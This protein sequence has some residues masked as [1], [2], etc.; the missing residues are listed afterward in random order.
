[1]QLTKQT[2]FAFRILIYLAHCPTEERQQIQQISDYF[3]ISQNHI[4]KIVVKLGKLGI[5]QTSRGQGGGICL[6]RP[7]QDI[8]LTDIV[9]SMESVLSP[10]NCKEPPC[11]ISPHCRLRG[12]LDNAMDAFLASLEPYTLNDLLSRQLQTETR[13]I[14]VR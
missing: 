11:A 8:K 6:A 5:L 1:M 2:D 7:P 9:R 10:V 3:D 14:S 4:A 12:L 13:K